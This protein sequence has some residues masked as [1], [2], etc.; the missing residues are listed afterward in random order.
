MFSVN[1]GIRQSSSN[2]PALKKNFILPDHSLIY[3]KQ[4]VCRA[5]RLP[6]GSQKLQKKT[7]QK[8]NQRTFANFFILSISIVEPSV[9]AEN[10]LNSSARKSEHDTGLPA[11]WNRT[12]VW[13]TSL[14]H[15]KTYLH[16]IIIIELNLDMISSGGSRGGAG[17]GGRLPPLFLDQTEAR[18]AEKSFFDGSGLGLMT[19]HKMSPR[20]HH[21][22][23]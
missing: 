7:L 9:P 1:V 4:A 13:K 19:F 2:C 6:Q 20:T 11:K 23:L 10:N 3:G 15:L 18:R 21:N 12:M 5:K 8:M 16:Q 22:Y 14:I 17:G